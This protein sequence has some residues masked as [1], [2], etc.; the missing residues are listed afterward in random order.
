MRVFRRI[1]LAEAAREPFRI[2]F[3]LGLL[4]GL[5]GVSLWP[6]HFNGIVSFY[7]GASH[8]RLMAHGFFGAFILGFL[9]TALPRLLS[10]KPFRVGEILALLGLHAAMVCA[11][12][13]GRISAG[14][15]LLL[16]LLTVFAVLMG[17][18]IRQRQ[19]MPPPGFV[20]IALAFACV[21]GGAILSLQLNPDEPVVFQVNLQHLLSYQGFVLLPILGVGAYII[22]RFFDLP[23]QQDF[24]ESRTPP[25]GWMSGA[26]AAGTAGGLVVASFF[27]E[28]AGWYRTGAGIRLIAAATYLLREIPLHRAPGPSNTLAAWLKTAFVLLLAGFLAVLLFPDRR[29]ALLHLT[30]VGGFAIVTM[31]VAT[32]V[33]FGH[34]GNRALLGGRNRWLHVATGLMLFA[35][36]TRISGD[37]FPKIMASHYNYGAVLWI[38]GALVWAAYVLPKVLIPDHD[39]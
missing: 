10:A 19:D 4:A 27:I 34:S 32:R 26:L 33:V 7:P 30:L 37:F 21:A 36:L 22:P 13:W 25:P 20:L 2:F 23:N 24:P 16:V 29:I 1:T 8:A 15:V 18:R 39:E 9:G 38:S 5:L 17:I 35:M 3:P 28:A 31:S 12:V 11:Y 6:L 14:D